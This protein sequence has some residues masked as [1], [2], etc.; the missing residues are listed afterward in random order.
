MIVTRACR[1]IRL[2]PVLP[3]RLLFM[4]DLTE[5]EMR[6]VTLTLQPVAMSLCVYPRTYL[7][8]IYWQSEAFDA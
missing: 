6:A 1:F 4:A 2:E 3:L 8:I 7:S 5:P